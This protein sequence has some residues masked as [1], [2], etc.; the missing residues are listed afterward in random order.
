MAIKGNDC[1]DLQRAVELLELPSF[2]VR[3]MEEKYGKD[4]LVCLKQTKN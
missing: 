1:D 4:E 3:C 2:I